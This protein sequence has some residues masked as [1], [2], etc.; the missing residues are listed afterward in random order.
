STP[1]GVSPFAHRRLGRKVHRN[2]SRQFIGVAGCVCAARLTSSCSRRFPAVHGRAGC[3]SVPYAYRARFMR[4]HAVAEL[5]GY[6]L[7]HKRLRSVGRTVLSPELPSLNVCVTRR[8]RSPRPSRTRAFLPRRIP[9]AGESWF[10][11]PAPSCRAAGADGCRGSIVR[12]AAPAMS[13]CPVAAVAVFMRLADRLVTLLIAHRNPVAVGF[14]RQAVTG[15]APCR[16]RCRHGGTLLVPP[17][18]LLSTKSGSKRCDV[19]AV[20]RIELTRIVEDALG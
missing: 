12:A 18:R 9:V 3:A 14:L 10:M 13:Q 2:H 7:R 5:R 19:Q 11:R 4:Q 6:A 8:L 15:I 17:R 20:E 16:R 1:L